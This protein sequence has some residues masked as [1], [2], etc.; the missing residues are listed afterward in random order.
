MARILSKLLTVG[1]VVALGCGDDD[2]Q[3][4]AALGTSDLDERAQEVAPATNDAGAAA[5]DASETSA[6]PLSEAEQQMLAIIK[7]GKAASMSELLPIYRKL[8]PVDIDFM[9]TTWKGGLFNGRGNG[10]WF[11]KQV[12]SADLAYPMLQLAS[13]GTVSQGDS[14]AK[15]RTMKWEGKTTTALVYNGQP[16][17]DYFMRVTPDVVVGYT[18]GIMFFHLTRSNETKVLPRIRG[19]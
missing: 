8:A 10:T 2:P 1:L 11:G 13:D 19:R 3:G 15:M 4:L 5:A 7:S 18:P 12:V 6:A 17:T 16:I 9:I 14:T